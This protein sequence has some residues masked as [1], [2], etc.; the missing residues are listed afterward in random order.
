VAALCYTLL[1][2]AKL[3]GAAP[4]AYLVAAT[5]RAIATSGTVMFPR[6]SA[7]RSAPDLHPAASSDSP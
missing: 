4:A 2:W 3:A 6:D 7:V 5:R 1:E